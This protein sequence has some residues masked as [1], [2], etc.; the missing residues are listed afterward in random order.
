VPEAHACNPSYLEVE[1][2][3]IAVWSQ[4]EQ[5]V[6]QTLFWKIPSLKGLVEW[7]TV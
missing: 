5:I 7:L 3:W 2:S 4:P 1:I 6:C